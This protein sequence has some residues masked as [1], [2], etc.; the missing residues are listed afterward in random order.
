MAKFRF[1]IDEITA[2]QPIDAVTKELGRFNE[3]IKD[4]NQTMMAV[5]LI[6]AVMVAG[7]VLDALQNR[8]A[9]EQNLAQQVFEL[10]LR[11]AQQT[12]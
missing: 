9:A 8:A 1:N 6:L 5:V 12:K 4:V 10:N 11:M 7:L 2:A 3:A